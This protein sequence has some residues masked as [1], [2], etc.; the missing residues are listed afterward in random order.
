MKTPRVMWLVTD[1][2]GEYKAIYYSKKYAQE[3][4]HITEGA[5]FPLV[6]SKENTVVGYHAV[7]K[8]SLSFYLDPI[9]SI[10]CAN[11]KTTYFAHDVKNS[12][13]V[14]HVF[15]PTTDSAV[16][17][18]RLE[19]LIKVMASNK[20]FHFSHSQLAVELMESI[21]DPEHDHPIVVG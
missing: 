17:K 8:E 6:F 19:L 4:A 5:A 3:I 21:L 16:A 2:D 20:E 15:V 7:I 11:T 18:Q 13:A 10:S 14:W 1:S 9:A 12:Q